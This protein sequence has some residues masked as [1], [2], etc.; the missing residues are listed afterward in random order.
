MPFNPPNPSD[1]IVSAPHL[2]LDYVSEPYQKPEWLT[3]IC[4]IAGAAGFVGVVDT[5]GFSV[6]ISIISTLLGDLFSRHP[7]HRVADLIWIVFWMIGC[8]SSIALMWSAWWSML[9]IPTAARAMKWG[10]IGLIVIWSIGQAM[11]L[12]T[13]KTGSMTEPRDDSRQLFLLIDR[14]VS[15]A[16]HELSL[17]VFLLCAALHPATRR[18]IGSSREFQKTVESSPD[19]GG[20]DEIV[21][22][23]ADDA[24]WSI[25]AGINHIRFW[26]GLTAILIGLVA[27]ARTLISSLV[28][29]DSIGWTRASF[30]S[31]ASKFRLIDLARNI[32]GL[33]LVC[34]GLAVLKRMRFSRRLLVVG[35]LGIIVANFLE[36][37]FYMQF[38][39]NT[40]LI[41]FVTYSSSSSRLF[42]TLVLLI[43]L[44]SC[45]AIR[46][47]NDDPR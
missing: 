39:W 32:A 26:V 31:T 5:I 8:A 13:Q 28:F 44:M 36:G 45:R 10:S 3:L 35:G 37:V 34:G 17:P 33:V 40:V 15:R 14:I 16:I 6:T 25:F 18:M 12:Y 30:W 29:H 22:E 7:A 19:S 1:P 21:R 47:Q 24:K 11:Q 9:R 2:E 41:Y 20:S 27:P 43:G 23:A 4:W 38:Q 42:T 46:E